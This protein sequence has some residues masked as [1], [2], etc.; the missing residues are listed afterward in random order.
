MY[1]ML[2]LGGEVFRHGLYLFNALVK[3]FKGFQN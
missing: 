3:A 1:K 2:K